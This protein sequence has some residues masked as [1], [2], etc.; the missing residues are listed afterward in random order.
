MIDLCRALLLSD[1]LTP[2]GLARALFASL[3]Q[4]APIEKTLIETGAIDERRLQEELARWDG[5]TIQSVVP[6]PDL[7][8][9][10]PK[11]ACKRLL[12]LPIR[13]DPRTGTIDVAVADG[14][15]THAVAEIG[16]HLRAPVRAVRAKLS[17]IL[18]VIERLEKPGVHPLAAPMWEEGVPRQEVRHV[19]RE[20]PMW[21]T[22]IV[23]LEQKKDSQPPSMEMPIPLL[24]RNAPPDTVREPEA[25]FDL[26]QSR[27]RPLLPIPDPAPLI[28]QLREAKDRD[29]IIQL[30]LSAAR[31]AARRA[32]IL[33]VKRDAFVGWSCTPELGSAE[34]LRNVM[35]PT[36]VPSVLAKAAADGTFLGP[37]AE[38]EAHAPLL[39]VMGKTSADVAIAPVRVAGRPALLVV[40]DDLADPALSTK[41]IDRIADEAGLA[42]ARIVRHR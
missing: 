15:A 25:S 39:A 22:P 33:V 31:Q 28:E 37:I 30:L 19:P 14:R 42:L 23:S 12:A 32:A 13:R 36:S 40:A 16:F 3:R 34:A 29:T 35:I 20:T 17:T 9:Q 5:P 41:H 6:I 7:V 8:A 24:R 2:D 18:A 10:L 27:R 11:G 1:A 21:G 26:P 38:T 4:N